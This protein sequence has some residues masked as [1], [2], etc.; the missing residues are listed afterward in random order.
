M[1]VRMAM[2]ESFIDVSVAVIVLGW[3]GTMVVVMSVS[4]GSVTDAMCF[5]RCCYETMCCSKKETSKNYF[6]H[7][8]NF[9]LG[10][11]IVEKIFE[12]CSS[13]STCGSAI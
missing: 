2:S 9:L 4:M 3:F 1:G 12:Y 5:Y 6:F 10:V 11:S 8:I 7:R 13:T